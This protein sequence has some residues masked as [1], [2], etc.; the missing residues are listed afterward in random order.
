MLPTWIRSLSYVRNVCAHHSRLWNKPLASQPKQPRIGEVPL[1][2]HLN[3][4][5]YAQERFYSA[6]AIAHHFQLQINPNSTWGTRFVDLISTFPDAPGI[7]IGQ[8]G[9]P[10]DWEALPLWS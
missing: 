9:F 7:S 3:G 6:A 8:A 10:A 2:D 5:Q 4:D 1:L